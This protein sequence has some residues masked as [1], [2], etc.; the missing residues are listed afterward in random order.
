MT[1]G[2]RIGNECVADIPAAKEAVISMYPKFLMIDTSAIYY[3]FTAY[4]STVTQ[5]TGPADALVL[6]I[7]PTINYV[8]T[9]TPSR[10]FH[11]YVFGQCDFT[12]ASAV[13]VTSSS[14]VAPCPSGFAPQGQDVGYDKVQAGAIFGFFFCFVM[15]LW[16]IAKNA[17]L[18]LEAIRKW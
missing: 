9:G 18:I 5:L 12:A 8:G 3:T 10:G 1:L 17:G 11:T 7:N 15:A 2:W 6:R 13:C 16:I 4:G 14:T